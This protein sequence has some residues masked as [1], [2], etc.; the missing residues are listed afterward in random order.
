MKYPEPGEIYQH[1][2]GGRYEVLSVSPHTETGEELVIYRSL[3]D[4][5]IWP[6]PLSMW[7][8]QVVIVEGG[9]VFRFTLVPT[10]ET[11]Q[12]KEDFQI[13]PFEDYRGKLVFK[14]K[15]FED[16]DYDGEDSIG[17]YF[18]PI[19][20]CPTAVIYGKLSGNVYLVK[21]VNGEKSVQDKFSFEK[22]YEKVMPF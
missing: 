7:F 4:G 8:E 19:P 21:H 5:K 1:Y 22:E 9:A 12:S 20:T 14:A 16:S 10:F 18:N 13:Q 6:R 3:E 2:K 17:K 11:Y 15:L